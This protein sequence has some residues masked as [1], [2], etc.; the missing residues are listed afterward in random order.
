MEQHIMATGN[1]PAPR[2]AAII[3]TTKETTPETGDN[4]V[5]T[6]AG[7]VITANVT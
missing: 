3:P 4:V 7:N 6:I 2:Q 5:S 1:K